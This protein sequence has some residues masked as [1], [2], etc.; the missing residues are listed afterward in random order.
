M[1]DYTA[2]LW[3]PSP[4]YWPS[5]YGYEPQAICM[6][7]TDGAMPGCLDWLTDPQ[8]GASVHY[9]V[10]RQGT[11][12]QLVSEAD[13]AWAN[14]IV[15]AGSVYVG[16]DNP[17]FWTI[18]IEHE[19]WNANTTPITA[20]QQLASTAL[21]ADI[22]RRWGHLPLIPHSGIAPQDRSACPGPQFPM[23]Q[24]D[25]AQVPTLRP[26]ITWVRFNGTPQ[27]LPIVFYADA[28]WS[29]PLYQSAAALSTQLAFDAWRYGVPVQDPS[30]QA[31]DS[32]WFHRENPY[33]QTGWTPS[34]W[35]DGNP[36]Q[37]SP[38]P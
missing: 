29:R 11:V 28:S 8:S 19:R 24:I 23:Q 22:R 34:A 12:Y 6:H 26:P 21:V 31:P 2:A 35:I 37:S 18:S 13:S 3:T 25:A 9:L 10:S 38:Q 1:P 7:G 36:P 27:R 20:A 4:N 15:E 16:R 32:R 14:G 5:R 17:N 33:G 30:T